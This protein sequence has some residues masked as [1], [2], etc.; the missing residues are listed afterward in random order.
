MSSQCC[1]WIKK[2]SIQA[3]RGVVQRVAP[4]HAARRQAPPLPAAEPH[5]PQNHACAAVAHTHLMR[6]P[7]PCVRLIWT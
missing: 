1:T 7:P 4:R 5:A 2:F 6:Q 3:Q